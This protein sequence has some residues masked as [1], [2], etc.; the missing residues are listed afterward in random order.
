MDIIL[1]LLICLSIFI[2]IYALGLLRVT[3]SNKDIHIFTGNICSF[4]LLLF[5]KFMNIDNSDFN[6]ANIQILQFF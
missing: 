2:D 6:K 1:Q 5:F 3:L 4:F